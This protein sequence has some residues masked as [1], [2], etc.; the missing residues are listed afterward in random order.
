MIGSLK[1][2]KN[3]PAPLEIDHFE[4]QGDVNMDQGVLSFQQEQ[5]HCG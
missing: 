1:G 5:K 3:T 2:K 4:K